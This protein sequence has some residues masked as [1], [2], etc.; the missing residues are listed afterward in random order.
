MRPGGTGLETRATGSLKD[1]RLIC[2]CQANAPARKPRA[3]H[4]APPGTPPPRC[5]SRALR[6]C[7]FAGGVKISRFWLGSGFGLGL[8]AFFVSFLPLSLFPMAASLTQKATPRIDYSVMR[9]FIG[10]PLSEPVTRQLSSTVSRLRRHDDGLRWSSPESWHITLQ[11]LGETSI[12]A[13]RCVAERLS[14]VASPTTSL[15]LGALTMLS[16]SGALVIDVQLSPELIALQRRIVAATSQCGFVT[17]S[18]PYH[19]H[20][21]LARSRGRNSRSIGHLAQSDNAPVLSSFTASEYLL[22]ESHLGP[23]GSKYRVLERYALRAD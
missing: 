5:R 13:Y 21:T 15:Q 10:I 3:A 20:I 1:F 4:R 22:Y 17:E 18:R 16:H 8:G 2:A 23:G 19:P 11:F 6:T 12:D 14:L 9:L 7:Y